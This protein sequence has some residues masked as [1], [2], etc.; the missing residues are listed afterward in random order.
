MR[1]R[2]F[3]QVHIRIGCRGA[4]VSCFCFGQTGA[5]KTYT[6]FGELAPALGLLQ[7][8]PPAADV[9]AQ[10]RSPGVVLFAIEHLLELLHSSGKLYGVSLHVLVCSSCTRVHFVLIMFNSL[11]QIITWQSLAIF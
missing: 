5:G 11:A 7:P 3:A 9:E 4:F 10:L 1:I 8:P 6:M 2:V